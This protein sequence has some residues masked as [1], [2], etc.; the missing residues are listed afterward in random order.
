MSPDYVD[1][2]ESISSFNFGIRAQM[3][4]LKPNLQLKDNHYKPNIVFI[5]QNKENLINNKTINEIV[6]SDDEYS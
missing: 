5:E 2:E 6:E 3:V 1:V 4:K